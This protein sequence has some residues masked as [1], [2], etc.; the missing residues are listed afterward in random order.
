V[1]AEVLAGI[2]TPVAFIPQDL[3]I[4][5]DA[6][7]PPSFLHGF[8]SPFV[9]HGV[10]TS[11]EISP[12]NRT[13]AASSPTFSISTV[14][15]LTPTELEDV[16]GEGNGEWITI[17]H[18]TFYLEDGNIEVVCGRTMSCLVLA[19][20]PNHPLYTEIQYIYPVLVTPEQAFGFS[21]SLH[22]L[23]LVSVVV[24]FAV[25]AVCC[26]RRRLSRLA[27]YSIYLWVGFWCTTEELAPF[28]LS[29]HSP[30]V[31]R[32]VARQRYS[33]STPLSSRFPPPNSET[34]LLRPFS[35]TH[36]LQRGVLESLLR[37]TPRTLR[38]Y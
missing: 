36:Q 10:G 31:G 19:Q 21:R 9:L 33:G 34:C 3:P 14:S 38:S 5:V 20:R 17:R 15:D 37:T 16:I 29:G 18:E 7:I 27:L 26:R 6:G 11:S 4:V 32:P 13:T 24:S 22:L 25:V 28:L 30:R 2:D 23:A 1:A 8:T 12:N 35:S